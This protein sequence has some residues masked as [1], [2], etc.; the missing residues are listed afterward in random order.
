MRKPITEKQL[1]AL[2]KQIPLGSLFIADYK[3]TFGIDED[4]VCSF[5]DGYLDY[6]QE[7]MIE[8]G[9]QDAE[10]WQHIGLYDNEEW[11]IEWFNCFEDCPLYVYEEENN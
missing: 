9:I 7:I 10:F 1:I 8:D 11:L 3:N 5:F 2:R 4:T 6:L